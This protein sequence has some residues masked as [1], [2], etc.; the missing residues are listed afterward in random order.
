[1]RVRLRNINVFV[2]FMMLQNQCL[3]YRRRNLESI[4]VCSFLKNEF[5]KNNFRAQTKGHF[6]KELL[7]NPKKS[8]NLHTS[9]PLF[10]AVR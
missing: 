8:K 7:G 5:L 2:C 1:M 3:N 4:C 10:P 6:T 9:A